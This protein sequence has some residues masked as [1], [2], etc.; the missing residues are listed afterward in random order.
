MK[1]LKNI[2]F[3]ILN[4]FRTFGFGKSSDKVVK[5]VAKRDYIIYIVAFLVTILIVYLYYFK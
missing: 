2:L 1:I 3:F 4:P 5:E